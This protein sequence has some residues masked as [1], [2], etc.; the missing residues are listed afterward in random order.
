MNWLMNFFLHLMDSTIYKLLLI[1]TR[2]RLVVQN[3][4]NMKVETFLIIVVGAFVVASVKALSVKTLETFSNF[5]IKLS[6][7]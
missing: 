2:K 7:E 6:G 5:Q 4:F 1:V 3:S